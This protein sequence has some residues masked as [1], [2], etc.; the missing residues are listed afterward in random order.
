MASERTLL[1]LGLIAGA[2]IGCT[3][4]VTDVTQEGERT[5][6]TPSSEGG[7]PDHDDAPLPR[8]DAQAPAPAADAGP[9]ADDFGTVPT[10]TNGMSTAPNGASMRPGTACRSCH[11]FPIAGTVFPTLHDG[12]NCNGVTSNATV[13]VVTDAKGA[14]HTLPLAP[15]GNFT[16]MTS[17]PAP[18]HVKVVSGNK[19]R[20]MTG[21]LDA[22][23]GNCNSCHSVY[24]SGT[25]APPGRILAP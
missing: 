24:G 22:S 9:D 1:V 14:S 25:P 7:A 8:S 18:F 12:D 2:V 16:S 10:C 21:A 11:G 3:A 6:P 19:E 13:V 20:A 15:G 17:F 4:A 5:L 23:M